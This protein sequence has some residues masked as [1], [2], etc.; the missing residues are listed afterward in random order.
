MKTKDNT[1]KHTK[2]GLFLKKGLL[3]MLSGIL[4][5]TSAMAAPAGEKPMGAD[6][7]S[8]SRTIKESIKFPN[9]NT[10]NVSEARVNVVFTVDE[11]GRVNL[12]VANTENQG[13]RKFIEEQFLT[14][15]LKQLKANNAYSIQFNFKTL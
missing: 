10:Y 2:G 14:L 8:A 6:A 1:G 4:I 13:L 11:A 15:S 5:G 3:A 12:V 9:L 7:E